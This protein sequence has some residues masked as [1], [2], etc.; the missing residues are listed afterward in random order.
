MKKF[1]LEQKIINFLDDLE[2][3]LIEEGIYDR[4]FQECIKL[5]VLIRSAIFYHNGGDVKQIHEEQ[6]PFEII[7]DERKITFIK[8]NKECIRTLTGKYTYSEIEEDK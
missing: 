6:Q 5:L 3:E 4:N 2:S 8:N 7:F 1:T